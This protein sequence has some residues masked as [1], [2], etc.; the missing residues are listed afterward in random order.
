[1]QISLFFCNFAAD[2][3]KL[4]KHDTVNDGLWQGCRSL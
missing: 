1:M 3:Y 2:N 4:G